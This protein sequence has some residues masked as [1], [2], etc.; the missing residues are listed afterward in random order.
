[1]LL[2]LRATVGM[3]DAGFDMGRASGKI[4]KVTPAPGREKQKR[5]KT[6]QNGKKKSIYELF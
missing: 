4:R 2:I 1:M 5:R 3:V 6:E